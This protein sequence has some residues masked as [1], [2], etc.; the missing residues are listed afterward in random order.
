MFFVLFFVTFFINVEA[1]LLMERENVMRKLMYKFP[2]QG[3]I[4][5]TMIEEIIYRINEMQKWLDQ[6]INILIKGMSIIMNPKVDFGY[7]QKKMNA[8]EFK[9]HL[10]NLN[11]RTL[12]WYLLD[13]GWSDLASDHE[14]IIIQITEKIIQQIKTDKLKKWVG[15]I[16]WHDL[17]I[18][19]KTNEMTEEEIK[20][21]LSNMS[22]SEL[23][24]YLL[25]KEWT[26]FLMIHETI[27][28]KAT[29]YYVKQKNFES[30]LPLYDS[31]I[32]A[33]EYVYLISEISKYLY[34]DE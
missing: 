22:H 16:C 20:L 23:N 14:T 2:Q 8:Q 6:E 26:N 11:Y 29:N 28:L 12:N 13:K 4:E 24:K 18:L 5:I 7:F 19:I 31:I 1:N 17:S 34:S 9:Q 30:S 27:L 25:K 21:E 10:S 3:Q 33:K 15:R 32:N